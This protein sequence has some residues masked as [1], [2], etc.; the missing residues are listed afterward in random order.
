[1]SPDPIR[2]ESK[3]NAKILSTDIRSVADSKKRK[4]YVMVLP[5]V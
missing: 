2:K 5:P 3:E 4:D 1:M